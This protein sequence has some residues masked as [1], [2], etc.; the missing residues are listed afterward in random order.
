MKTRYT[1][2]F[3]ILA[4][5]ALVAI[6]GAVVAQTAKDH[7]GT[8]SLVTTDTCARMGAELR[9]LMVKQQES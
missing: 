5:A 4:G 1:V 7:V 6:P 8:W 3:P 9:H 2:V